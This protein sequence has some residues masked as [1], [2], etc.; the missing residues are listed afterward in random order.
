MKS[1][2]PIVTIA[3]PTYNR[4]TKS[5]PQTLAAAL[6]Q[7]YS[8]LEI[9]VSD[10]ASTDSTQDMLQAIDD[11]RLRYVRHE[12]NIGA[13]NN[14]N[15]CVYGCR[16]DFFMLL[17]DDDLI[18]PD[19]VECCIDAV[20]QSTTVGLI[21]TGV[22]F[23]STNNEVTDR[24]E[25][26]VQGKNFEDLMNA[27]FRNQTTLYCCNTL[28]NTAKLREIGG[29]QSPNNLF[30]DAIAQVQVASAL[31][32]VNIREIKASFRK[33]DDNYGAAARTMDWCEDSKL[34]LDCILTSSAVRDDGTFS[35]EASHFLSRMNYS[36]ALSEQSFLRRLN[37]LYRIS[38]EFASHYPPSKYFWEKQVRPKLRRIK[39]EVRK[40]MDI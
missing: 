3:I 11:P 24:I 31:G 6:A 32:F 19:F 5:M 20:N 27:W 34:L 30:Q 25:N 37:L 38:G 15:S 9:L 4:A 35:R 18:D 33:H 16:G 39:R 21:R 10:N 29:F 26:N 23:I 12:E 1:D 36:F 17:P 40:T 8:N 2:G 14:F 13:N 7:T 22:R 28:I